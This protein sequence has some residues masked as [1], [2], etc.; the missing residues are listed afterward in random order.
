MTTVRMQPLRKPD[1]E[2]S[3]SVSST[4][5]GNWSCRGRRGFTGC[6][7]ASS[8]PKTD[9]SHAYA[10]WSATPG[11][12]RPKCPKPDAQHKTSHCSWDVLYI[13]EGSRKIKQRLQPNILRRSDSVCV[14][15][16]LPGLKSRD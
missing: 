15:D 12:L 14:F 3:S 16:L 10:R 6:C 5:S 1:T 13:R 8:L 7:G 9:A 4:V 11:S 2:N